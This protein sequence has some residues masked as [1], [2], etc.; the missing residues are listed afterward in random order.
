MMLAFVIAALLLCMAGCFV[1]GYEF[2]KAEPAPQVSLED[3]L[4]KNY[5]RAMP[6]QKA[7]IPAQREPSLTLEDA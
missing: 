1:L 5:Q 3:R 7:S 2:H 4:G 6:N